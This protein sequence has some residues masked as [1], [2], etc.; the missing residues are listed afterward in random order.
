MKLFDIK[1]NR[2]E[3]FEDGL[4]VE[5]IPLN[6]E[7]KH[8]LMN[9]NTYQLVNDSIDETIVHYKPI[10]RTELY[11]LLP[12][13]IKLQ[14]INAQ[15]KLTDSITSPADINYD[16][17][18]LHKKRT[19]L[20]G[21]L[22][23]VEYFKN[24]NGTDYSDLILEENRIYT[25]DV[26]GLVQTRDLNIKWYLT[27]NTVGFEKNTIKYYTTQEA[28]Q[29]GLDRRGNVI[30]D[31][32]SYTLSQI[33]QMYSFD[34]LSGVKTEIELFMDG[35]TQPL[36]NAIINSTKPYLT[37]TIKDGIIDKLRLE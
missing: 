36:R 2:Y 15:Y 23:K 34:L 25:R 6:D 27:N 26:N 20:Y 7:I 8:Y 22:I 35:Y 5:Y 14:Y 9:G 31:T 21:E 10:V 19:I 33:G 32:K 1:L 37:Q 11:N 29:E 4:Y 28:I 12:E 16:I 13:D 3:L 18:G 24:Y 17:L 30:A